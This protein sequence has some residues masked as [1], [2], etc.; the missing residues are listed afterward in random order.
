MHWQT[1]FEFKIDFV[2]RNPTTNS[3]TQQESF[4][5]SA[6]RNTLN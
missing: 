3:D 4:A 5:L 1:Y 6:L 2:E